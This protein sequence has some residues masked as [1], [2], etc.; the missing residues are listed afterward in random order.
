MFMF[1]YNK[2]LKYK[3]APLFLSISTLKNTSRKMFNLNIHH[4][5]FDGHNVKY[6][7][8]IPDL[9]LSEIKIVLIRICHNWH[10]WVYVK[11]LCTDYFIEKHILKN[12][13]RKQRH[14]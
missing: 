5:H 13:N 2:C 14:N 4:L 8:T 3:T 9:K 1:K 6:G 7:N 10:Q 12:G 11:H